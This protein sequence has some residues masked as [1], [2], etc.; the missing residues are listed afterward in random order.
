MI[1]FKFSWLLEKEA[2]EQFISG[3]KNTCRVVGQMG[4]M[5]AAEPL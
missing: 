4:E 5:V 2:M 3:V 1:K